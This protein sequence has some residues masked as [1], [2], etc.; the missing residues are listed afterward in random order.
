[1]YRV[2]Y[3]SL[4]YDEILT[5]LSSN[6]TLSHVLFQTEV[7]TNIL[8]L[9]Y[10]I[11]HAFLALSDQDMFLRIPSVIFGSLTIPLFYYLVNHVFGPQ[12]GLW[13]ST[14]IAISP[15]H[16]FYSQEARPYTMFLFL[17]L[18]AFLLLQLSIEKKQNRFLKFSFIIVGAST[19]YCHTVAI[20]FLTFLGLYAVIVLSV[21][22]WRHWI[23]TF[24]TLG[25]L[26]LPGLYRA[27]MIQESG[28]VW[29][30]FDPLLLPNILWAFTTG[31]SFGPSL[32]DLHGAERMEDIL[33]RVL[34]IVSIC[35]LVF[36]LGLYG[37]RRSFKE[38]NS[39]ILS[40][41][42]FFFLPL[43]F[44]CLG[45]I[46]TSRPFHVRHVVPS[47]LPFIVFLALGVHCLQKRYLKIVCAG[48]IIFIS[49]F[50]LNNYYF[51]N[52]YHRAD[53]K[54]VANFL[55]RHSTEGDLVVCMT[56]YTTTNLF[57]YLSP[58]RHVK[59][60]PFRPKSKVVSSRQLPERLQ[61]DI[62]GRKHFWVFYKRS[63]DSK[64]KGLVEQHLDENYSSRLRFRSSNVKLILYEVIK[65][66]PQGL[67]K[68]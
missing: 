16:I 44:M 61:H 53:N 14:F 22:Q 66:T 50:S 7:K 17:C 4:W 54:G 18:L 12:M 41:A 67:Q 57:Y 45:A 5:F 62:A 33:P 65:D 1:M 47:F 46:V 56:P 29:Q 40:L 49:V 34:T 21:D 9:Y 3:Q 11:V 48:L 42:L 68:T 39:T 8:P 6:G 43:T 31:F 23:S 30:T 63:L 37:A 52:R 60:I 15:F 51:D 35:I 55:M 32:L 38:Y 27:F 2:G 20:P 26:L 25:I 24:L 59:I 28:K 36:G 58:P 10:L 19:F 13:A 64:S